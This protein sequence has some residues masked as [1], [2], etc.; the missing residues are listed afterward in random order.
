[1]PEG[2]TLLKAARTLAPALVG[3]AAR[4]LAAPIGAQRALLEGR[5]IER[6]EAHGKHLLIGFEGGRALSTH[7]GMSGS[8]HLYGKGARWRR[9]AHFARVEIEVDDVIAVCFLPARVEIVPRNPEAD[10]ATTLPALGPDLLRD[11]FDEAE[12]LRRLRVRDATPLGVAIMDQ[13]AIAGVGN[14][15]KSESLFLARLDPFTNVGAFDD[16]TLR[17]LLQRLRKLMRANLT[18]AR[19]TTR[20]LARA[21]GGPRHWVYD[22][23]GEPCLR[24][25]ARVSMR[26]QGAQHRSTY[27]C[28]ACQAVTAPRS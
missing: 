8:W 10:A 11:D 26:R 18:E 6:V 5:R 22:R 14:V 2:D 23:S 19:R 12:A 13:R 1:L 20:M 3:K 28:A 9:P 7:L 16:D 15:Y 24:C 21:D 4:R 27:F 17:A 25:G